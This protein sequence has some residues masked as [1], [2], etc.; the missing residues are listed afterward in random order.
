MMMPD[1]NDAAST[2][3]AML[4]EARR[5]RRSSRACSRATRPVPRA[6]RA[7]ARVSAALRRHLRAR[8][9]SDNAATFVKYLLEI[10]SGLVTASVPVGDL[11]LRGAPAH[12]RC[13]LP[14]RVAIGPQ[15]GHSQPRPGRA[16]RR[17]A[18]GGAR[19]RHLL[20]ARLHLRGR[21]AAACGDRRRASPRSPS[22]R[23]SPPGSSSSPIGRRIRSCSMRSTPC[24]MCSPGPRATDWSAAVPIL[25]EA[26]NLFVVGR[27]VG[28]AVA[29][30]A[31]LKLKE[32][33]ASMR[34][35]CRRADARPLD[36]GGRPFPDPGAQPAGR[37]L[38]RRQRSRDEAE[39]AGRLRSSS[40]ERRKARRA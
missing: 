14:R 20:A 38:E 7:P 21:A 23:R 3:T 18:D 2:L 15:P 11:R 8:G 12:A 5:R 31:A 35:R 25:T 27:G 13:A 40:P 30:E 37:D 32:T 33:R 29:Q 36:A 16:G 4:R 9:S 10:H 24:P 17:R 19:E 28:F 22:S 6:R 34:R 1:K 39:G 26:D